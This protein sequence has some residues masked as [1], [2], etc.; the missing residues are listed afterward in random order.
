TSPADQGRPA[1]P[2][3]GLEPV[4]YRR[5]AGGEAGGD[6]TSSVHEPGDRERNATGSGDARA[7]ARLAEE[8]GQPALLGL[9]EA[10]GGGR[11]RGREPDLEDQLP[12]GPEGGQAVPAGVGGG[13]EPD[14]RGLGPGDHGFVSGRPI[15]FKMD[16]YNPLYVGRPT[17]EPELFASLRP[18]T[19]SGVMQRFGDRFAKSGEAIAIPE[20]YKQVTIKTNLVDGV[21]GFVPQG[22]RVD[23]MYIERLPNGRKRAAIILQDILVLTVS[24]TDRL[25]EG[26]SPPPTPRPV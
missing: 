16:L 9:G 6:P 24:T 13:R 2:G 21:G 23:V 11:L 22:A 7:L 19:Y 25:V 1:G 8:G 12:T 14:R 18:P 4:V 5:H 20:G 26:P 15:S 17:V 10:E 3:S